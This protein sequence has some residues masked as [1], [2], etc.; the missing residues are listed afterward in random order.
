MSDVQAAGVSTRARFHRTGMHP[1][2]GSTA[3]IARTR[4]ASVTTQARAK[5]DQGTRAVE[6]SDPP[7][8]PSADAAQE[9][10][11]TLQTLLAHASRVAM[12]GEIGATIAHEVNQPLA[13][14]VTNGECG[15]RWLAG[16]APDLERLRELIK[17]VVADARR[18]SKIVGNMRAMATQRAPEP[19]LLSLEEVIRESIAFLRHELQSNGVSVSFDL[20]P[21]LPA[22]TGD[23][24]Q[25]QQVVMNL[26]MNAAQAMAQY[27]VG[28]KRILIRTALSDLGAVSCIVED[29]G[30]GI[31]PDHLPRLFDSFFTTK[32]VGMGL[33]LGICRSILEAHHGDIRADNRSTLGGARL[34]F[35][36]PAA[37][38]NVVALPARQR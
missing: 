25:L 22:V 12:L 11:R 10:L 3:A 7:A 38:E 17:R 33:G 29:S 9:D 23:R 13:A 20:A 37:V 30:P 21:D 18:A 27:A 2:L 36:L 15:L 35:S 16:P 34:S 19:T 28:P 31:N 5:P 1:C 24:T 32:K 6:R 14:I 26:I 8:R 4:S